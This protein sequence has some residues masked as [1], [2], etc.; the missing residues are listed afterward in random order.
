M[1]RRP[2]APA[3]LVLL[4][5]VGMLP[6]YDRVFTDRTWVAPMLLAA[7]LAAGIAAAT[8]RWRRSVV[9]STVVSAVALA[10]CVPWLVGFTTRPVLPTTETLSELAAVWTLGIVELAETPAPTPT[11]A[12]LLTLLVVAAWV[13]THLA[14]LILLRV[15]RAGAALVVLATLWSVPLV[16]PLP[17]VTVWPAAVAFLATAGVLLLAATPRIETSRDRA[18]VPVAGLVMGGAVIAAAVAV[19]TLLPGYGAPGWYTIG[20][21][22]AASPGYQPIVDVSERLRLPEQRDVLRLRAS[23]RTYLRL[24]GLDR[25]DGFTWRLG[26]PTPG[27]FRPARESLVTAT[28]PLPPE[29]PASSTE[30][31]YVDVEVLALE[32]IYVPVPYQPVEVL[33]PQR[34]DMVW[35]T[36]GGFLATYDTDD[37]TAGQL[38]VGVRE[39]LTYRVEAARPAPTFAE[40]AALDTASSGD[41]AGGLTD[42]QLARWTDLPRSY[43][44]L[45]EQAEAVYAAAGATTTVEQA[46][47]LQDWF[48]GA[49]GGFRYDL[50][51]PA[52]RGDDALED[53]VLEDRVGYCEYFATAMAV[54]LRATGIPARVAVGF[55][56]GEVT[57]PADPSAGR[58]LTE[59]TVSTSDAHAWVEVLFPGYGWVTFEPTPR[60]DDTQIVPTADDLAPIENVREREERELLEAAEDA[61]E[62]GDDTIPDFQD[63]APV[64]E[65]DTTETTEG[66]GT[67]SGAA[68]AVTRWLPFLVLLA[69]V[70]VAA[71]GA[72]WVR[73][74]RL[75]HVDS[76]DPAACILAA[77]R[78]LLT[79]ADGLGVGRRRA[80]TV[81][82]VVRRW[83]DEGRIDRRG[84]RFA[85]LAQAAA[86]GGEVGP[87][88]AREAERLGASLRAQLADSVSPRAR[89]LAPVRVPVLRV[90]RA[91]R[92]IRRDLT[93]RPGDRQEPRP[94][95]GAP[96]PRRTTD[97]RRPRADG[98]R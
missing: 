10:A 80:E 12:G 25:F 8:Q 2:W 11:L 14:V 31:V 63:P 72:W 5:V 1:T 70:A 88:D 29:A 24:A 43:P 52:L 49:D 21:S 41:G 60:A 84:E 75:A 33:G 97:R 30:R 61:A 56:P 69:L 40:L 95:A 45:R 78:R 68:A 94:V 16:V 57:A 42:Q 67:G 77:Q 4:V 58:E 46:L 74:R 20:G 96:G 83:Q 9:L 37:A 27:G 64:P 53:F 89:H 87:D 38:R 17:P 59:F 47:A 39:G 23:Q 51:V 54:M 6:A 22:P 65:P 62:V 28:G 55:L 3:A 93:T 13:V 81:R 32:N 98:V 44:R 19:P 82:E 76:G 48:V 79:T 18:P 66:T 35:S 90:S 92:A 86:F 36:D 71:V 91:T 73:D 15:E 34:A 26:E 50:D 7:V 85:R